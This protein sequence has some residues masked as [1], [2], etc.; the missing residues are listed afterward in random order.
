MHGQMQLRTSCIVGAAQ[1]NDCLLLS[2][3]CLPAVVYLWWTFCFPSLSADKKASCSLPHLP[4][5]NIN[6]DS[7][8]TGCTQGPVSVCKAVVAYMD[9]NGDKVEFKFEGGHL[10]YYV[11]DCLKVHVANLEGKGLTLH[12]DGTSLGKWSSAQESTVPS[13][14]ILMQ[15]KALLYSRTEVE[16]DDFV[17]IG[18]CTKEEQ[19]RG[20]A[21]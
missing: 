16:D 11:N 21:F 20:S 6:N 8:G 12:L 2:V 14:E 1:R 13:E 19:L 10:N 9:T 17:I 18:T 4:F 7:I 15:I 3:I 5:A